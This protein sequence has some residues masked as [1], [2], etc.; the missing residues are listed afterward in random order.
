MV[1][2]I[3]KQKKTLLFNKYIDKNLIRFDTNSLKC[4]SVVQQIIIKEQW[5]YIRTCK[6]EIH[7]FE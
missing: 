1:Y 2:I 6:I 7:E 5:I 4:E 3:Y